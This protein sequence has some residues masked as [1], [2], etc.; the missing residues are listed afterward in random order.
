MARPFVLT[1]Y[2]PAEHEMQVDCTQMLARILLPNVQWTAIDHAHSLDRRI[3][4][5]GRPIG[6]IQAAQRKRRGVKPGIPDFLFW[7]R[8]MSF[9]IELKVGDNDLEPDQEEFLRGLIRAEVET[10]VC[11]TKDQVFNTVVSWG[12][13]RPMRVAA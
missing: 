13:T 2:E 9:A 4:R 12:L 1:S 6:I 11:W 7:H 8:S 5:N 3:G 10:K